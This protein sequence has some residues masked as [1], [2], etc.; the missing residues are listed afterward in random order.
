M[1]QETGARV[2]ACLEDVLA[3]SDVEAVDLPL[4]HHLN[5]AYALQSLH[6]GRHVLLEKPMAPTAQACAE[7]INAAAAAG[8]SVSVAENTR[9]VAAYQEV[10]RLI[11]AGAIGLPRVVRT[12]VYGSALGRMH[13]PLSW[14]NCTDTASG[15]AL[16]DAA[17]HS[18][19]LLKWLFG[20]VEQVRA[21]TDAMG[22][23]VK[24][25][26]H[27]VLAGRLRS[28]V[29][30]STEYTFVAEIPWGER[31]EVYGSA[32]SLLVDQLADPPVRCFEGPSD[33]MGEPVPRVA[34]DPAGWKHASIT[35]GVAAF[36][37]AVAQGRR[38]PIAPEDARD[39][40]HVIE[41]AYESARAGG[42]TITVS[43]IC[44]KGGL[45]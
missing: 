43:G 5:R 14:K 26:D 21:F 19:Y 41:Q 37:T 29:R 3:D 40:M 2:A 45:E 30:F 1:A 25:E 7:L 42:R 36:A 35:A 13:D 17:P 28:G 4:P 9:F 32:G 12:H 11:P 23:G 22:D 33:M 24:V 31:L 38:P 34:F 44:G 20:D 15:G 16:F 6:S 8:V 39:G 18:L 27:A 10:E